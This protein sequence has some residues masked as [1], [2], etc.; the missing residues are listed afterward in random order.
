MDDPTIHRVLNGR[1]VEVG[2]GTERDPVRDETVGSEYLPLGVLDGDGQFR[3]LGGALADGTAV[4]PDWDER[5][6]GE[7][8]E[9]LTGHELPSRDWRIGL[10]DG[11]D[12][13]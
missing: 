10:P 3:P 6:A 2:S 7:V 11:K 9:W 1:V 8:L 13:R 4:R 12:A 5:V